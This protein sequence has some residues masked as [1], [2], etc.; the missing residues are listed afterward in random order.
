[1]GNTGAIKRK[2]KVVEE[3]EEGREITNADLENLDILGSLKVLTLSR[4]FPFTVDDIFQLGEISQEIQILTAPYLQA[5]FMLINQYGER[6]D[7]GE[8]EQP[9]P[10]QFRFHKHAIEFQKAFVEL[11]SKKRIIK[12]EKLT[13]A[14]SNIPEGLLS[15]DDVGA[16]KCVIDFVEKK[17]I[18]K[19]ETDG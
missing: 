16:L 13:I 5:K 12:S 14:K 7:K 15:A 3:K 1:M 18:K 9:V 19:E 6:N 10:G 4:D 17:E 8:L 2:L 11:L